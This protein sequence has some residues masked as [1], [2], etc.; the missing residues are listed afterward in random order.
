MDTG[1]GVLGHN[2]FAYCENNP[3]NYSDPDGM[4]K[5]QGSIYISCGF[6][7]CF[8]LKISVPQYV[9][10]R[11]ITPVQGSFSFIG[12]VQKK[13]DAAI[14]ATKTKTKIVPKSS[15]VNTKDVDKRIMERL[16]DLGADYNLSSI[17]ISDGFRTRAQQE[18]FYNSP[19]Y[20]ANP[21]GKSW[22]EYGGA[23]DVSRCIIWDLPN[24]VLSE[25]GLIRPSPNDPKEI[26]HLQLL[27]NPIIHTNPTQGGA[28]GNSIMRWGQ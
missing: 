13:A 23:V 18:Y 4:C 5:K 12:P 11:P 14:A 3:V 21:P 8:T 10:T 16:Q 17:V 2:M 19:K 20:K 28:Y 26:Q 27:E 9:I 7:G 25:Y 6:V 15:S 22:H 1:T 24:S